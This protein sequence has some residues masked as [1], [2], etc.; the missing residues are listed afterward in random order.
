MSK[1]TYLK[2]NAVKPVCDGIKVICHITNNRGAW[3]SG[4]VLAVSGEWLEPEDIYRS[5]VP[6][7]GICD[8]VKVNNDTVVV[9]MCAQDGFPTKDKPVACHYKALS[10]CLGMVGEFCKLHNATMIAPRIGCGI[11][12]AKWEDIEPI[13]LDKVCSLGVPVQIYDY[14]P[15]SKDNG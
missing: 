15:E 1:I 14:V 8:F 12:G 6:I 4:F 10:C 2:G 3:G 7:L 5:H 13:I 11:G 9:N